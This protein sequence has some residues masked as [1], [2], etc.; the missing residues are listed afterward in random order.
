MLD[1]G[2]G[3]TLS[4]VEGEQDD[5]AIVVEACVSEEWIQPVLN[6]LAHEVDVGVVTLISFQ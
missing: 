1:G 6:P 4:L 3:P 2:G 5:R